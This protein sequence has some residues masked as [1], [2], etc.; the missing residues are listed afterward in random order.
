[1]RHFWALLFVLMAA[2]NA[3]ADISDSGSLTIGGQSVIAGTMTVQGNAFSV[4]G[5][6]FSVLA[7]TVNVSGLLKVSAAGIQWDDGKVSTTSSSGGGGIGDMS[8]ASTQTVTG[9]K[10]FTS[11]IAAGPQV[12]TSTAITGPGAVQATPSAVFVNAWTLV[13]STITYNATRSTLYGLRQGVTYRLEWAYLASVAGVPNITF[14]HSGSVYQYAANGWRSD[15]SAIT[16]NSTS[17]SECNFTGNGSVGLNQEAR[18]EFTFKIYDSD[19]TRVLGF[20]KHVHVD[21]QPSPQMMNVQ[22][23]CY[24][25]GASAVSSI[26]LAAGSNGITGYFKLYE[27]TTATP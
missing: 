5:S 20:G 17:G 15:G 24:Y 23:G 27:Q 22:F 4:G 19:N 11:S 18:G 1:M 21:G 3:S 6:T 13:A 26:Q 9:A 7:G 16:T 2:R 14:N 12:Q 10:V 25:D 8:L